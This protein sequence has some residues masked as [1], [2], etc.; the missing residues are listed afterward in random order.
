[1]GLMRWVQS[2]LLSWVLPALWVGGLGVAL[3]DASQLLVILREDRA[4][5]NLCEGSILAGVVLIGILLWT[6]RIRRMN[7]DL[8]ILKSCYLLLTATLIAKICWCFWL[9]SAQPNDMWRYWG[10]GKLLAEDNKPS[11]LADTMLLKD[12]FIRR[13][14]FYTGL[15]FRWLGIGAAQLELANVGLQVATLLFLL[16]WG[17]SALGLRAIAAALPWFVVYP[18]WW[19]APTLANHDIPAMFFISVVLWSAERL[20]IKITEAH[21]VS[22]SHTISLMASVAVAAIGSAFLNVT[23]DFGPFAILAAIFAAVLALMLAKRNDIP[24]LSPARRVP[25]AYTILSCLVLFLSLYTL[26]NRTLLQASEIPGISQ[27]GINQ[28]ETFSAS[29]SDSNGSFST[30][31]PWCYM[32]IPALPADEKH[33]V[34]QRK[35]LWEKLGKRY[36]FWSHLAEKKSVLAYSGKTMEYAFCGIDGDQMGLWDIEHFSMHTIFCG[37]VYGTLVIIFLIR[38]LVLDRVAID[39]GE[40]AVLILGV[41]FL[42]PLLLL[43]EAQNT[44]D[45]VL[46]IPLGSGAGVIAVRSWSAQAAQITQP[47]YVRLLRGGFC[48]LLLILSQLFF[49]VIVNSSG[50]TF[51]VVSD[52][53]NRNCRVECSD[54]RV[55][56]DFTQ[57]Q[58]PGISDS[59]LAEVEF[60]LKGRSL[61]DGTVCC[62]LSSDHESQ[63][64]FY[65]IDWGTCPYRWEIWLDGG[66]AA[67]GDLRDL[68]SP[69]FLKMQI[70]DLERDSISCRLLIKVREPWTGRISL[71][72][73]NPSE[74]KKRIAIEYCH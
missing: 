1:M 33:E 21:S 36:R 28:L 49:G 27:R 7:T 16:L 26:A 13:S 47:V 25:A 6:W 73:W 45:Q 71:P 5:T 19:F 3:F 44:Y 11:L 37:T 40:S 54:T 15:I 23:R 32:Y 17:Q 58:Y 61:G 69:K 12:V 74:G 65:P 22:V 39:P 67:N 34:L 18:D 50:M 20:R 31:A 29:N 64:H 53:V 51:A 46:A 72:S 41:T 10:Y 63:Q 56:L 66:R 2:L 42:V 70:A 38:L 60:R 68:S 43:T 24:P 55:A 62:F 48:L 14:F 4:G 59:I 57:S 35:L 30:L 8:S 9:D 52:V